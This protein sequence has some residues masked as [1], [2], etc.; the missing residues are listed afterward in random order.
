MA[1][2]L[3]HVESPALDWWTFESLHDCLSSWPSLQLQHFHELVGNGTTNILVRP[4]RTTFLI[5]IH[6]IFITPSRQKDVVV[7]S[8]LCILTRNFDEI[9]GDDDA[10]ATEGNQGV[11]IP[12]SLMK[13]AESMTL[14]R[15]L[16]YDLYV[17]LHSFPSCIKYKLQANCLTWVSSRYRL[18]FTR[19]PTHFHT[20]ITF[21]PSLPQ[22]L[23]WFAHSPS[24]TRKARPF[25]KS[26]NDASFNSLCSALACYQ[27]VITSAHGIRKLR[28][29]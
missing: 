10:A 1:Q 27:L 5:L 16:N 21:S 9:G 14:A 26:R 19:L 25:V 6:P 7:L 11:L 18:W 17:F 4:Y 29:T 8:E 2:H 15:D 13:S 28:S 12:S 23:A 3:L 24:H 22:T 20:R